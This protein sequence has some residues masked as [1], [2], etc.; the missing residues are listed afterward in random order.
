MEAVDAQGHLIGRGLQCATMRHYWH[1][2]AP[3]DSHLTHRNR[4]HGGP[5]A[6]KPLFLQWFFSRSILPAPGTSLD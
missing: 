4:Q 2:L 1:F 5:E 6:A 3:H